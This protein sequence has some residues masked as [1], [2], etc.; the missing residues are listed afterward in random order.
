MTK[1]G[2]TPPL[3]SAPTSERPT[4]AQPAQPASPDAPRS[5]ASNSSASNSSEAAKTAQPPSREQ[6]IREAAYRRF[7][8]RGGQSADEVEDWLQAEAEVDG[9]RGE[10]A[11]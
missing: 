6:R 7:Q 10:S 3:D 4:P 8:Q 9:K 2:T 11:G 1:T 5:S